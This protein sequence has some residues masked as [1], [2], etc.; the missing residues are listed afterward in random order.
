MVQKPRG[1]MVFACRVNKKLLDLGPR[2]PKEPQ[3]TKQF[4]STHIV[5]ISSSID[6]TI[7][8]GD[9]ICNA[10]TEFTIS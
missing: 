4:L 5:T 7:I 8:F 3:K 9:Q 10:I 6:Q 2:G 1:G